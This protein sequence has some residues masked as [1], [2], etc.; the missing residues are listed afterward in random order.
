MRQ[1]IVLGSVGAAVL[2]GFVLLWGAIA[3]GPASAMEKMAAS[4]R[5]AKSYKCV[6][7]VKTTENAPAPGEPAVTENAYTV[8]W[9]APGSSRTESTQNPETWRGPGP[10]ITEINPAGKPRIWICHADKTYHRLP[11][12]PFPAYGSTFDDLKNLGNFSGKADRELGAKVFDGK[13]RMGSKSR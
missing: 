7:I 5:Q 10:E 2:L 8:Y 1:G 3:P 11:A 13:R 12:L 6:Q 9:M 4:V